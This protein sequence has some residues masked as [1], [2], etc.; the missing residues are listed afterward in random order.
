[1][2]RIAFSMMM[3]LVLSLW[4]AVA[5][6]ASSKRFT[7]YGIELTRRDHVMVG[8]FE[9]FA[10]KNTQASS[11]LWKYPHISYSGEGDVILAG[12]FTDR[13]QAVRKSRS[14]PGAK[15]IAIHLTPALTSEDGRSTAFLF[16]LYGGDDSVAGD[17]WVRREEGRPI[18]LEN[19]ILLGAVAPE[20]L[21][22]LKLV[23]FSDDAKSLA[24]C[25]GRCWRYDVTTGLKSPHPEVNEADRKIL[26][27]VVGDVLEES[28]CP[29]RCAGDSAIRFY[30]RIESSGYF[31]GACPVGETSIP[32]EIR[33]RRGPGGW[34]AVPAPLNCKV[35][36]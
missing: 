23:G 22:R 1:M 7:V 5:V 3:G 31:L 26:E 28:Y 33:L 36:D 2:A 8:D 12:Y 15:V 24:Y 13:R 21:D 9:A 6:S 35:E 19:E 34:K 29:R 30:Q 10:A 16:P 18:R 20:N 17:L 25:L 32:L 27:T 11:F 14:I 4:L